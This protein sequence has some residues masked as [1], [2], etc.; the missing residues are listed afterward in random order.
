VTGEFRQKIRDILKRHYR[1]YES[2]SPT[3]WEAASE[4]AVVCTEA[5]TRVDEC[6]PRPRSVTLRGTNVTVTIRTDQI[7][8]ATF[9][10]SPTSIVLRLGSSGSE[11]IMY[12]TIEE[13]Q[14]A[15]RTVKEALG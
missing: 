6:M 9:H 13:A 12:A 4:I 5:L 2:A 14:I 11:Q 7:I 8:G 10:Y 1:C 15:Y 3:H